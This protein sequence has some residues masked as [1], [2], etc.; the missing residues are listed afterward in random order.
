MLKKTRQDG[1]FCFCGWNCVPTHWVSGIQGYWKSLRSGGV[2]FP[3][4]RYCSRV[5][6]ASSPGLVRVK[7]GINRIIRQIN[8]EL[9]LDW[10]TLGKGVTLFSLLYNFSSLLRKH[11]CVWNVIVYFTVFLD[12]WTWYKL[13]MAKN[14]RDSVILSY[15]YVSELAGALFHNFISLI[16]PNL[17]IARKGT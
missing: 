2:S 13:I 15:P 11:N 16:L 5:S 6:C 9:L 14:V 10:S 3:C 17:A 1:C 4:L 8:E 12:Y 7:G